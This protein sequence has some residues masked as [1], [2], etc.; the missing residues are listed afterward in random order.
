MSEVEKESARLVDEGYS[1]IASATTRA[2]VDNAQVRHLKRIDKVT[3]RATRSSRQTRGHPSARVRSMTSSPTF[4]R[5][6]GLFLTV[7]S[8]KE[9]VKVLGV[10][11]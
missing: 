3:K 10:E 9:M 5:S 4:G 1:F 7:V 2:R 6:L 11:D 8:V